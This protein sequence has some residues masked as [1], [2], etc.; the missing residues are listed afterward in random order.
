MIIY[1]DYELTDALFDRPCIVQNAKIYPTK[2]SDYKVFSKYS[3]YILLSKEHLKIPSNYKDSLLK[4]IIVY[5]ISVLNVNKEENLIPYFEKV[6]SEMSILFSIVCR[7]NISF[8]LDKDGKFVF[9]NDKKETIID[10]K[11]FDV[12][13]QIILKVNVLFEPRIYDNEIEAKWEQ[14]AMKARELK[15]G[16]F[17]FA[18]MVTIV[19]CSTGKSYEEIFNGNII[20]LR[21]D[22]LRCVN[23]EMAHMTYVFKTVDGKFKGQNFSDSIVDNLFKNPYE[24]LWVNKNNLTSLM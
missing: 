9:V 20:Q 1:G 3:H 10:E 24:G 21:S 14:K 17:D 15:N 22:F 13:R 4:T 6:T 23:N 5:F 2:I 16:K 12:I 11:N 19:S 7:E 18:D 8:D